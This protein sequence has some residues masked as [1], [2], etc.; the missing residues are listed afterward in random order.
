MVLYD[1]CLQFISNG[2]KINYE[3]SNRHVINIT[4]EIVHLHESDN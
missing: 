4:Q 1:L 3:V 2:T